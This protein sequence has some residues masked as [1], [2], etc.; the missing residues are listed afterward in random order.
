M[1]TI[2]KYV[3]GREKKRDSQGLACLGVLNLKPTVAIT[4]LLLICFGASL[5]HF[6]GARFPYV[7]NKGV[8]SLN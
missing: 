8:G 4:N 5:L 3:W 1:K 7:Q 6:F 2:C